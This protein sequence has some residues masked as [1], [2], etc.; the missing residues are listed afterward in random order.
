MTSTEELKPT[1]G[2]AAYYRVS[3]DKQ[4]KSGL[5]LEAQRETV[6][7]HVR[8]VGGVIVQEFIEIESGRKSDRPKLQ[9]AL[10][11]CRTMKATLAIAKLDRLARSVH[12]ISG[13][14]ESK[15][16]FTVC[17]LPE[18][19]PITLHILAAVAQH[20]RELIS[21]RTKAALAAA[22]A[23]GVKLGAPDP[24]K[25]SP[26]GIESI[27][28]RADEQAAAVAPIIDD[29]RRSGVHTFDGIALALN[30]RG[31]KSPRGG[32]WYATS[33]RRYMARTAQQPE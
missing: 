1:K 24:A 17:D 32:Y 22:K 7:R 4:G 3:T 19:T 21:Q 16:P 10:A 14:M 18:A 31:I 26:K 33:V 23:R 6:E 9:E 25:A 15:V 12:F 30:T 13:L 28:R 11:T 27:Q 5:G 2:F 29:I 8:Q 20:E